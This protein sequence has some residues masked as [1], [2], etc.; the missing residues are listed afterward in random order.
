MIDFTIVSREFRSVVARRREMLTFLGSVFAALGVFLQNVLHGDLPA[1][2]K[3]MEGHFFA[4]FAVMLM[5]PSLI[6]SLRMAR[7]HAGMVINGVFYARLM[8]EQDYARRGDPQRAA[9]HRWTSASFLT[10]VLV[11]VI[12]GFSTALLSLALNF[13]PLVAV[14]VGAS[15][16]LLWL[17]LYLRFH[18]NAA[19]FALAKIERDACAPFSRDEWEAHAGGSLEDVNQDMIGVIAFVGLIMFSM[20]ECLSGLGAKGASTDLAE[21]DVQRWGPLLFTLLMLV[22]CVL[23]LVTYLRLRVALGNF[24][25][26]LDPGDRPFRA[27]RLTDSLLGYMLL[28]FLFAISLHV[29]LFPY[30]PTKTL[31]I[32]DAVGFFAALAVEQ[33][34]LMIAGRK[35]K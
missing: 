9:R 13:S 1:A 18:H 35:R 31:L 12:A 14:G 28:C 3:P 6:L 34:L 15:T 7:L 25:L 16:G 22:T 26:Q 23:G 21:G 17:A 4:T 24:A 11:D 27:F 33:V 29:L 20:F 2:L 8:Q 32:I 10:F 19:K 30:V 5:A